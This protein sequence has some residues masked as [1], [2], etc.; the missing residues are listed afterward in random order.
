MEGE[1]KRVS[2]QS[3]E[4]AICLNVF[5]E[6]KI[7][8]CSHTFCHP[9]L[10][11]L[12]ESQLDRK[13]LP[14]PVCRKVTDVPGG[15]ISRVQTNI[16]LMSLVDDV[17]N[18]QQNC[19]NC[20]GS[21]NPEAVSYCQEC[22]KYFCVSC[23]KTHSDWVGF[24]D[25]PVSSMS[26]VCVGK[27]VLKRRR[28]CK[29][30][31]QEDEE[32]FCSQCRRYVCF[33]C[34]VMEHERKGHGLVEFAEHEES[35]KKNIEDLNA[36]SKR[37]TATLKR[38]IAFVRE[39]RAK[40]NEARKRVDN[41]VSKANEEAVKQLARRK[42]VLRNQIDKIFK[43]LEKELEREEEASLVE[44][45]HVNAVKELVD[46]GLKIPLE[47]NA[48]TAHDTLCEDLKEV[49]GRTDPKFDKPRNLLQKGES[50][51][52]E[53]YVGNNELGL[54]RLGNISPK[55]RNNDIK[56]VRK[57]EIKMQTK[58]SKWNCVSFGL[59]RI[60]SMQGMAA[61]PDGG[62]AIGCPGGIEFRSA[63]G[64][65]QKSIL[66]DK[67]VYGI[68]FLTDGRCVVIKSNNVL[69]IC[70]SNGEQDGVKFDLRNSPGGGNDVGSMIHNLSCPTLSAYKTQSAPGNPYGLPVAS[71]RPPSPPCTCL[72]NHSRGGE[73]CS[74]T[75]DGDNHI[76]VLDSTHMVDQ[77]QGYMYN[78]YSSP[79]SV[80]LPRVPPSDP[81]YAFTPPGST[82]Y[83]THYP[84][85]P[86]LHMEH[87]ALGLPS[88]SSAGQ[89]APYSSSQSYLVDV[90]R[91]PSSLQS[92]NI[93]VFTPAGG[94]ASGK[95][96]C[97]E[98]IT[99]VQI[100]AMKSQERLLVK[101][102]DFIVKVMDKSG[103]PRFTITKE[104]FSAHAFPALS[105]D[106][107]VLIAWVKHSAGI[108]TI[109]RYTS[110]LKNETTLIANHK[111]EKSSKRCWYYLQ[112][113]TT[114]EL[115]LCTT[116]MLYVFRNS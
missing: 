87:H 70:N 74:L 83:P 80:L 27:V 116:D 52:F 61:T 115:A 1:F 9:C 50:L 13:K 64:K 25:H 36:K 37:K 7:L 86:Y 107:S 106:D 5:N 51:A 82:Q 67:S 114:G 62:M 93:Q 102:G 105:H 101:D 95:I 100:F 108:V 58:M 77:D 59:S 84:A 90:P 10:K 21:E 20:K 24:S 40:L 22:S 29:K 98:N 69:S 60:D 79:S 30:H 81:G 43:G 55:V 16:A 11:R 47:E 57:P 53:R 2:A 44:I 76:Y 15:D 41:H 92:K 96:Y 54:G 75:V 18:Q 78:H 33:R 46:N 110:D 17:K 63:N 34:G 6:P 66:T 26:D 91:N 72:W 65:L 49:L 85:P 89:P 68:G 31:Q 103:M 97:P 14:C 42:E 4:C 112:E 45:N 38:Y 109:D 111:I 104:I 88:A 35:M 12:L 32:Y 56:S 94:Q 71:S 73:V 19:T 48:L 3:L 28:K 8:S 39:Q 113:F 23:H 99:P